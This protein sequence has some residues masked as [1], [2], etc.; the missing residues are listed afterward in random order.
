MDIATVRGK[1]SRTWIKTENR[2]WTCY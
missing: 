1:M 2:T